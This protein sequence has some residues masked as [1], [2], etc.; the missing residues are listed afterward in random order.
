MFAAAVGISID[1][2]CEAAKSF[3][4]PQGMYPRATSVSLEASPDMTS[5]SVPS[6]PVQQ[7]RS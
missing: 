7:T 4:L 2:P 5:L 3:V 6:P 1:S